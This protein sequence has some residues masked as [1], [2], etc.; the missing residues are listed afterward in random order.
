MSSV[1]RHF[2]AVKEIALPRAA[3][4]QILSHTDRLNRH[5]GLSPVQYEELGSDNTGFFRSARA[6]VA[7]IGLRWREYPFQWESEWRHSVVRIYD[8]GP[9]DRFEGGL[10]LEDTG[11]GATKLTLFSNISGRGAAGRALVPLLARQFMQKTLDF[12]DKKFVPGASLLP[13]GPAPARGAI[14]ENLL[15]RLVAELKERPIRSDYADALALYLRTAGDDEAASLRPFEW[16]RGAGLNEHEALRTCLHG[17]KTGILNM[18]WAMM[19]PNCRVSKAESSSLGSLENQVHC[20]LCGVNY[21]LNFDRYVE[22]KFAV[23]PAVRRAETAIF[24][25]GG[26]FQS[27][28]ILV[29]KRVE[30]GEMTMFPLLDA[31][32]TLRLRVLKHNKSVEIAP[33]A[34]PQTRLVWNG[35]TWNT[36][37][38]RG[39]FLVENQSEQAILVALEKTE[40]DSS[41]VTAARVTVLQEFRD[42]FSSEVL[43][44]GRQVAVENVTLFFSDLSNSTALYESIGDAPA[45][46]RVGSHFDFLTQHISA[47]H[48][49]VVKT[50]G[51]AV[52][53]VFY[54]PE[55]AVRAALEIQQNFRTFRDTLSESGGI[56]L[57]IGLHHGPALVVNSND[58]LDYFGRTVNIAARVAGASRQGDFVLTGQVWEYSAVQRI[59]VEGQAQLSRFEANLRGVEQA[60]ALVRVRP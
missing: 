31:Q 45:F 5:I 34:P 7:G 40:W 20:D 26:P 15:V 37:R 21:D 17:V 10:E 33:D 4:W 3:V 48:G 53:A 23:H 16:A 35:K 30:P 59:L 27:P 36:Q 19:C 47:N 22:L 60:F 1:P 52:M 54:A 28:H 29:Q 8:Q 9:I 2:E 57:K 38:V 32:Q 42:L 44:P 24:C 43:R 41:A 58:R 55:D 14:D 51:D 25:I 46:G 50:M 11:T 18:R 6:R 56:D 13:R 39:P 12:C 49:A